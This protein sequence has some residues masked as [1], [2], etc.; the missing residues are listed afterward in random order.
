VRAKLHDA[1]WSNDERRLPAADDEERNELHAAVGLH[2]GHE[3]A[4]HGHDRHDRGELHDDGYVHD[5]NEQQPELND[6]VVWY[7]NEHDEQPELDDDVL[8]GHDV[9]DA[10]GLHLLDECRRPGHVQQHDE[11]QHDE[12]QH[13]EQQYDEQ[14]QH[15]EQQ[16]QHD[17]EQ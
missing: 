13:D 1:L 4:Q 2:I 17:D 14:Q 15:D 9:A 11:Q 5:D 8:S 16:Q 6:D 3:H 10:A 7:A 12:R